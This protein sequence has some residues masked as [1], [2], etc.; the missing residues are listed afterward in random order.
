M[1]NVRDFDFRPNERTGHMWSYPWIENNTFCLLRTGAEGCCAGFSSIFYALISHW[2]R[3]SA[4]IHTDK[5]WHIH[6]NTQLHLLRSHE[7]ISPSGVPKQTA[8]ASGCHIGGATVG[9]TER[10]LPWEIFRQSKSKTNR[11]HARRLQGG[12]SGVYGCAICRQN[13]TLNNRI[14]FNEA[15]NGLTFECVSIWLLAAFNKICN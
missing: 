7:S 1:P 4:D 3:T 11:T 5:R 14:K 10:F 6:T 8:H 13:D 12:W 9:E 2:N 15:M